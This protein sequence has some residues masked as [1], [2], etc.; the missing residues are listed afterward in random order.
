MSTHDPIDAHTRDAQETYGAFGGH[1]YGD[2]PDIRGLIWWR[3]AREYERLHEENAA[4]C[5][6]EGMEIPT[7]LEIHA[8]YYYLTFYAETTA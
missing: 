6:E 1:A 3:T 8:L 4:L 5:V 7:G 2:C